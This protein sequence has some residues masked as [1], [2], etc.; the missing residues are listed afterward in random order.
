MEKLIPRNNTSFLKKVSEIIKNIQQDKSDPL[1]YHQRIIHDYVLKYPDIRGLLIYWEMGAGKTILSVSICD[2]IIKQK[3]FKRVIFI[4]SRTLHDNFIG[5]YKKY[6]KMIQAPISE[7]ETGMEEYIKKNCEFVTLTA[8]NMLQQVY[9]ASRS[10]GEEL[11]NSALDDLINSDSKEDI[12]KI[13]SEIKKLNVLGNLDDTFIVIDEAHNFFN[14]ITN[15]SKNYIGLYQL[16]MEARNLKVIFL[17]GSPITND[18]F[19]IALCFNMLQGYIKTRKEELSLFGEDYEDFRRFFITNPYLE[20][21][22]DKIPSPTIKNREKFSNRIVGLVSYY[23]TDQEEIQKL[24]P[25]LNDL[26]VQKVPMSSKQYAS[27]AS[28][29]DKETEENKKVIFNRGKRPLQKPGGLSSSYRVRSRQISNFLYPSYASK[30]FKDANGYTRYEKY[31]D[32]LESSSFQIDFNKY[33][34]LPKTSK[35]GSGENEFKKLKSKLP[36]N[37]KKIIEKIIQLY[38]LNKPLNS[39]PKL[40]SYFNNSKPILEDIFNYID[41][42]PEISIQ[43]KKKLK[44]YIKDFNSQFKEDRIGFS[45]LVHSRKINFARKNLISKKLIYSL[46]KIIKSIKKNQTVDLT[47]IES[48]INQPEIFRNVIDYITEDPDLDSEL[49]NK[50]KTILETCKNS[51]KIIPPVFDNQDPEPDGMLDNLFLDKIKKVYENRSFIGTGEND[52]GLDTWS[53]KIVQ[54]LTNLSI[55]LPEGILEDFKKL[56]ESPEWMPELKKK[57][58]KIG[59]GPG[60]IY[61]Q[62]IDSGIGLIGKILKYYGMTEIKNKQ[63][64]QKNYQSGTF[65]I[66]SGEVDPDFRM[67]IVKLC[68]NPENKSGKLISLLL[69]TSTGAEGVNTNFM[70]HVHALEPFWHWSRLAQVFARAVRLGSHLDLPESERFVQPYIYLS[71]YPTVFENEEERKI[72]NTEDTTDLTL[73]YRAVQN[74]ILI[75]SFLKTLKESSIDCSIH[76]S[77]DNKLVCK[78]C[79]PSDE[80]L[81]LPDLEADL[82][83]PSNCRELKEEKIIAES[84]ILEENGE[85]KEFMFA[86]DEK[87]EIHI[88]ELNPELNAYQEIFED[89][90]D[91]KLIYEKIKKK[92]KI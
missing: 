46:K 37:I 91:Y 15:G 70:K 29:R 23:G 60:I 2:S 19:E 44:N 3:T 16:I 80:I 55:H 53:P 27:Y 14:G 39:D 4:S 52:L 34:K 11:L 67:E 12:K 59:I 66:I 5:D 21:K 92:S 90:P 75:D 64:I 41:L 54:L 40:F 31:P 38:F 1:K 33:L 7:T 9:Q 72:K 22:P 89:H 47:D 36:E 43:D 45:D 10:E 18:P 74:Q 68:K 81:F 13:K 61:S 30:T 88:F 71:D 62:F 20:E 83:T 76:Y 32:K 28:A 49:K 84:V 17:T 86:R 26:I 25:K 85:K 8:N 69:I 57:K 42:D 56:S 63:D 50:I 87:K 51:N 48:E 79:Q 65:A 77:L 78:M 24:F 6:L 82:R 58:Q 73:Y 35:T